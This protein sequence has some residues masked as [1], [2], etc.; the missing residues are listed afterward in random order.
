METITFQKLIDTAGLDNIVKINQSIN[1]WMILINLVVAFALAMFIYFIYKITF[2]GVLYSKSF[3]ITLVLVSMVTAAVVMVISSNIVL[4]LGM[5]G[6]LSIVRF[7]MA[8]KDV[9]DI[10][11][12]FWAITSGII[13]GISAYSLAVISV[14]VIGIIMFV[15][16]KRIKIIEPYLL[17]IDYKDS[18]TK[19]IDAILKKYVSLYKLRSKIIDT[20][21]SQVV[22]EIKIKENRIQEMLNEIRKLNDLIYVKL[23]SYEGDLEEG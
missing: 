6:A 21:K 5:V 8:V 12:L 19:D 14:L 13:C 17:I 1:L 2:S 11:F 18:D 4:A 10:G 7:R 9:K 3:N 20:Q 16:S 22:I 23:V 15:L